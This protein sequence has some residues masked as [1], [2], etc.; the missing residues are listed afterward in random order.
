MPSGHSCG[1]LEERLMH[2]A[3]LIGVVSKSPQEAILDQKAVSLGYLVQWPRRVLTPY[4]NNVQLQEQ[5]YE[6]TPRIA[7][8]HGTR[9]SQGLCI[10]S[11]DTDRHTVFGIRSSEPQHLLCVPHQC[12]TSTQ[13]SSSFPC[14]C[15][16]LQVLRYCLQAHATLAS[17]EYMPS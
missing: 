17:C 6:L 3:R 15:F 8:E 7:K 9:M 5:S 10:D 13:V 1:H 11:H 14:F 16:F 2:N 4:V 12:Q